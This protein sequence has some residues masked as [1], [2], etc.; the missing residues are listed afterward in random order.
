MK[1]AERAALIDAI[2]SAQVI[3][4]NVITRIETTST[5]P[6]PKKTKGS[7]KKP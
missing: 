5:K 6:K 3:L 2:E 1:T 7:N 4:D